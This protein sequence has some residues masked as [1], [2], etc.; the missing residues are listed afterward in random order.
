MTASGPRM[1]PNIENAPQLPIAWC[2]RSRPSGRS[3]RATPGMPPRRPPLPV[4]PARRPTPCRAPSRRS[5][6]G[7]PGLH[8]AALSTGPYEAPP[9]TTRDAAGSS[10]PSGG[11][12]EGDAVGRMPDAVEGWHPGWRRVGGNHPARPGRRVSPTAGKLWRLGCMSGTNPVRSAGSGHHRNLAD[13]YP[14]C[15]IMHGRTGQA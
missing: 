1:R 6:A 8:A 5:R 2:T 7:C 4:R 3:G 11:S 14:V 9:W 13:A 15:F 10:S 12:D